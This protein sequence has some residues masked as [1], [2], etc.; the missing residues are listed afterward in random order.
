[1][2]QG[3]PAVG[4]LKGILVLDEVQPPGRKSMPGKAFLTGARQWPYR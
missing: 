2:H 1:V 3:L 4:T